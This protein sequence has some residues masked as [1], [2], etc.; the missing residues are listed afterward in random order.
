MLLLASVR[1]KQLIQAEINC[2]DASVAFCA[3]EDFFRG[4]TF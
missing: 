3:I 4:V 1:E 2:H